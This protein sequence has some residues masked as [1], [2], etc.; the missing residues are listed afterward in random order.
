MFVIGYGVGLS[1]NYY[2]T[3]MIIKN[4]FDPVSIA[5]ADIT[6]DLGRFFTTCGHVG[7]AM[8]FIKSW[9]LKFLQKALAAVGKMTLSN[10]LFT[11]IFTTILFYGFGFGLYGQLERYQLYYIVAGFWIFQ[12][13]VSPVWLKYFKYGPAEWLWQ[14]LTYQKIQDFRRR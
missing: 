14:S 7:L 6:Y 12:L 3:S 9:L 5:K 4:N 13:I 8:L 11:A 2:E 1:V 10:Y